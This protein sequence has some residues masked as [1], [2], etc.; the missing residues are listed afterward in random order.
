LY[1]G[2]VFYLLLILFLFA[3]SDT[4]NLRRDLRIGIVN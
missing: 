2:L 1:P 4:L 3:R